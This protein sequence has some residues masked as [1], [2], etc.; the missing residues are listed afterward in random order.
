M[1]LLVAQPEAAL[2][3]YT[4]LQKTLDLTGGNLTI[5]L[6]KLR[7]AGY[8][9]I[10]KEY[11]DEKPSTWVQATSQGRQAFSEYVTNLEKVLG[12]VVFGTAG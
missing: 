9:T 4:F 8:V 11:R 7:D 3:A 2:I 1:T 12:G 10:T 6:R 5:H